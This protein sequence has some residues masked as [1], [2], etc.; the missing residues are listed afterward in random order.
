M[1]FLN[2]SVKLKSVRILPIKPSSFDKTF[3]N[4]K[5]LEKYVAKL[6]KEFRRGFPKPM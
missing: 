5:A 2:P 3:C 6:K 1:V 4:T